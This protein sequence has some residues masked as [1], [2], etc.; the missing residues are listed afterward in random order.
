MAGKYKLVYI[1]KTLHF[2]KKKVEIPANHTI[3]FLSIEAIDI[4][5]RDSLLRRELIMTG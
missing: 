4:L 3:A 5:Y 2:I 1:L